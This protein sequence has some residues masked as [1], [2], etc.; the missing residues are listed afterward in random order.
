MN[1]F[2]AYWTRPQLSDGVPPESQ[3]IELWDFELL[4]WLL[5][6][7]EVRRHSPIQ[8]VTDSRGL[9]AVRKAG[10][11]WLYNGGISTALDGIPRAVDAGIF[12]AAGKLYAY[13]EVETPCVSLDTDAVLWRPLTPSAPVMTL[14][15]ED[16]EWVWYRD[17]EQMFARYGFDGPGWNWQL[18]PCNAGVVCLGDPRLLRLYTD[19]AIRFMEDYAG[20][21]R[22]GA[23]HE[24]EASVAML[25]AEQRLLPMC[26]DRLGL[27]VAPITQT[28][29][30]AGWLP[31]NLDCLHLWRA[32][33]AYKC[34]PDAR[35]ELVRWL[36]E[37]LL[38][39]FPEVRPTLA[40]WKLD[41]V[42]TTDQTSGLDRQDLTHHGLG[43]LRF[44]LLKNIR[45]VVSVA[46]PIIGVQRRAEEGSMIWSA[47]TV[48][49]AIPLPPPSA[50]RPEM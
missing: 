18:H 44:S 50:T 42:E 43:D 45:G 22:T 47:E 14:H 10:I 13:R 6:V 5:S 23:T 24:V 31:E 38:T 20:A 28:R 19:T 35:R 37:R 49:P 40:R 27:A 21:N 25:F 30:M 15:A 39:Q 3:D 11:D 16:R 9:S 7:L 8:L 17:N 33:L 4:I 46:D 1:Y 32:K 48:T 36:I 2:H 12:W 29:P 34:C 41:R 26:A